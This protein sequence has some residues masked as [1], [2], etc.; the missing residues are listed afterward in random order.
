MAEYTDSDRIAFIRHMIVGE[1][2]MPR[3][4]NDVMKDSR[5]TDADFDEA[6]ESAMRRYKRE[7]SAP[8]Q[9]T[10]AWPKQRHVGR[11]DDMHKDGV[12]RVL[13]QD[14]GDVQVFVG[15][16]GHG[17]EWESASIEFCAPGAGGGRSPRTREALIGLMTA[18]EADNCDAPSAA[19][20][21]T[22]DIA[23]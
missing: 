22:K 16:S 4:L 13:L 18:I 9:P 1:G 8:A 20:P 6:L 19:D 2:F 21:L 14:D 3:E 17:E 12:L 7:P 5:A 10:V 11:M 23:Q 15:S